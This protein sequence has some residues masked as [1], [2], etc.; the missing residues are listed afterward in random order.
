MIK[1]KANP[2]GKLLNGSYTANDKNLNTVSVYCNY[3]I[4][5]TTKLY[6]NTAY[7]KKIVPMEN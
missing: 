2:T 4:L 5:S 7:I 1:Q 6:T 3:Y